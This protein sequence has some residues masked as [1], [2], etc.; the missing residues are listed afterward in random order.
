MNECKGP[1]DGIHYPTSTRA[2]LRFTFLFCQHAIVTEESGLL[3]H[4]T[5]L[6]REYGVP[7]VIGLAGAT[8]VLRT[9]EWV[10]IDGVSGLVTRADPVPEPQAAAEP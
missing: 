7:A 10:T 1:V 4:V 2:A 3:S 8:S 6:S 5:V 9:G